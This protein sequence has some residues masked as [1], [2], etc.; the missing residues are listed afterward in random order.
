MLYRVGIARIIYMWL[1]IFFSGMSIEKT[2]THAFLVDPVGWR[3]TNIFLSLALLWDF[4][5]RRVIVFFETSVLKKVHILRYLRNKVIMLMLSPPK[6]LSYRILYLYI[7][8]KLSQL[9]FFMITFFTL[10]IFWLFHTFLYKLDFSEKLKTSLRAC[11]YIILSNF[12]KR[13]AFI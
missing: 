8:G 2:L 4:F 11:F 10:F 13:W 6:K 12:Y 5:S 1:K 7:L 9:T 3:Q